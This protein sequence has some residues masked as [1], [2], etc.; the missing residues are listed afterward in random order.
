MGCMAASGTGSLLFTDGLTAYQSIR[1][2]SKLY[3][4]ILSIHSVKYHKTN[5]MTPHSENG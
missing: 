3:N 4:V 5:R 1:M 2:N